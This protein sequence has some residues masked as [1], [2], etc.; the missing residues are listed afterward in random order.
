MAADIAARDTWARDVA[1]R[2]LATGDV[3]RRD[4]ATRDVAAS[5]VAASEVA[6]RS[7]SRSPN[8]VLQ[9]LEPITVPG[10]V[11]DQDIDQSDNEPQNTVPI[12]SE[13]SPAFSP[14]QRRSFVSEGRIRYGIAAIC[15]AAIFAAALGYW[16]GTL[17]QTARSTPDNS[18]LAVQAPPADPS[19][20][21]RRR[22]APIPASW[23]KRSASSL[24]HSMSH[25]RVLMKSQH[26]SS[27]DRSWSRKAG[28]AW[29]DWCW[30]KPP[31]RK[32]HPQRPHSAGPMI[33]SSSDRPCARTRL[34]TWRWRGP[35]TRKQRIS[36]RRKPHG[37]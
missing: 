14:H 27:V 35:G 34:L 8:G 12:F 36:A 1:T 29:P 2:D 31:R 28:S 3:A 10:L 13:R 24:P 6:A 30:S 5:E 23:P 4:V 33:R 26:C 37:G 32:A 17:S 21:C 16:A 19:G 15:S 22:P 11:G 25:G 9:D 20:R 18:R 7:D